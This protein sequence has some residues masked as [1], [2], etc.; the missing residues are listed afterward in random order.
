MSYYSVLEVT[1]T[2]DA[3]VAGYIE[4]ANRLVAAHGGK[5]LART[6][7]HERLEGVGEDASLR[8]IIEWPSR[9]AAIAFMNDPEY[10]PHLKERTE[11]SISH[12]FLIEAKDDL[13]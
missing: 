12:H 1:P 8:I 2:S 13:A 10:V 5:Y 6:D 4:P 9:E 3:W 7:S 11:G